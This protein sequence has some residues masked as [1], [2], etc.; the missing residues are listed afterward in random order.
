MKTFTEM[1]EE[2]ER[3]ME[4]LEEIQKKQT[5]TTT[6]MA[7]L[8]IAVTTKGMTFEEWVYDWAGRACYLMC[9]PTEP[10]HQKQMLELVKE[11]DSRPEHAEAIKAMGEAWSRGE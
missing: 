2:F 6:P 8:T 1:A 5:K 10:L 9:D 3:S 4:I 11:W 7:N